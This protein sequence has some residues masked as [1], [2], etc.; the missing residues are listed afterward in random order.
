MVANSEN[1][2]PTRLS[3]SERRR[4]ARLA[5]VQALYQMDLSGESDKSVV[6]QFRDHHFGAK[7]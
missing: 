3:H 7:T 5:A 1:P 2:N 6:R 4:A